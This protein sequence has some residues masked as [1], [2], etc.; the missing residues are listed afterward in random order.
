MIELYDERN[1]LND[2]FDDDNGEVIK[3]IFK[4]IC[5]RKAEREG[6]EVDRDRNVLEDFYNQTQ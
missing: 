6:K 3:N 5:F 4:E 1:E 2:K